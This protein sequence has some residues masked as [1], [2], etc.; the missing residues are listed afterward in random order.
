M[1]IILHIWI[2]RFI[3]DLVYVLDHIER[4][5]FRRKYLVSRPINVTKIFYERL[6]V[7]TPLPRDLASSNLL[8]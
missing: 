7:I 2:F 6:M 1:Y 4:R 3:I 8:P 5:V